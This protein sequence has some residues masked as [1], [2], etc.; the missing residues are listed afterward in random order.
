MKMLDLKNTISRFSTLAIHFT[1]AGSRRS[2][3]AERALSIPVLRRRYDYIARDNESRPGTPLL[4][5]GK[6]QKARDMA[7]SS[8]T[9][10][11]GSASSISSC[12]TPKTP[13]RLLDYGCTLRYTHASFPGTGRPQPAARVILCTRYLILDCFPSAA[14]RV[15]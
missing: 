7:T 13:C 14:R 5:V 12:A 6:K 2:V 3:P 10:R 8:S 15:K 9:A 4:G 1:A 11:P